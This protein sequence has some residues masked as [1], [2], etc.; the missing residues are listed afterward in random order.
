MKKKL[1]FL[2][3]VALLTF[4]LGIAACGGKSISITFHG[5]SDTTVQAEAGKEI[6]LPS[7][8]VKAGY[9]FGG[10]FA[11]EGL[12]VAFD[13]EAG[14]SEDTEVWAKFTANTENIRLYLI[15]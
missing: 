3:I 5:V 6:E 12:T 13:A 11:D 1:I 10:W 8:P 4:C 14:V 9:T 15:R 7:D 2:A